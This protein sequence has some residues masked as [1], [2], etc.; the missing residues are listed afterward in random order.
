M[1]EVL[2]VLITAITFSLI[3]QWIWSSENTAVVFAFHTVFIVSLFYIAG[4]K[5]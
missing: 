5:K 3:E 2:M 4:S 1:K